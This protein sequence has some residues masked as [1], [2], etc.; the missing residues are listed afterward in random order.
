MC[1]PSPLQ[2]NASGSIVSIGL[3][4]NILHKRYE[5]VRNM[6]KI[7]HYPIN[8][9]GCHLVSG[10]SRSL[11]TVIL[12]LKGRDVHPKSRPSPGSVLVCKG[13]RRFYP[14]WVEATPL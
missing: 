2:I 14:P 1:I 7:F 11:A 6:N 5:K 4:D 10:L 3:S 12:L 13:V 9:K 8:V